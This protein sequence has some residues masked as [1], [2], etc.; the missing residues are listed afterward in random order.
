MKI[1]PLFIIACLGILIGMISVIVYNEKNQ[2][3]PPSR[4]QL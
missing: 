2:P 1:K 4:H 3:Q